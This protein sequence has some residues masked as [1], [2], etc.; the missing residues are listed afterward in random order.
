M[1]PEAGVFLR[2]LSKICSRCS[3]EFDLQL[4]RLP[5]F[6]HDFTQRCFFPQGKSRELVSKVQEK[7]RHV[8]WLFI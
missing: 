6:L 3:K 7:G 4:E 8:S 2:G 5:S 1:L